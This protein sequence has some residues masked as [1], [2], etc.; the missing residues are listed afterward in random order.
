MLADPRCAGADIVV[1]GGDLVCGPQP[2]E[3]L[4]RLL[5]LGPRARF[6]RGNGDRNVVEHGEL[7][8]GAWCAAELGPE[9][10]ETVA[11]WPLTLELDV[12]GGTTFCHATPQR[13]D[14]LVT[15]LTPPD[16]LEAAFAAAPTGLVVVGHTHMQYDIPLPSGRCLVNAGSVGRPYEG[17]RGAFW[18]LL[19]DRLEPMRTEYDVE[20]A[21]ATI[22]ASAYADAEEHASQLL[23]PPDPGEVA[24]Y[25]ESRRGA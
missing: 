9:R 7:H 16:E 24:T 21:A 6:L 25:F 2:V 13:D 12:L 22:R 15:R 1:C 18:T 4:D 5:Q 11:A 14:E 19:G 3:C 23:E 8:G 10:L 20:R 17:V